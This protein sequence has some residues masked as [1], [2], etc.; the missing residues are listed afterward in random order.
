MQARKEEE[1]DHGEMVD[2]DDAGACPELRTVH[3]IKDHYVHELCAEFR[4]RSRRFTL[5]LRYGHL[6]PTCSLLTSPATHQPAYLASIVALPPIPSAQI[7][8]S[9]SDI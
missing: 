9:S 2:R 6:A 8:R 4:R 3:G 7:A 1:I 5:P